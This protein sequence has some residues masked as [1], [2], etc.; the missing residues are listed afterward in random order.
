MT[1]I[2]EHCYVDVHCDQCGEFAVRA[3]VIAESQRLLERGCPGSTYECPPALLATLLE[4]N[5]LESLERAWTTLQSTAHGPVQ[6]V[7]VDD[8]LRVPRQAAK[9]E[10]APPDEPLRRDMSRWDD[11][12]GF[13][14]GTREL[15]PGLLASTRAE[16]FDGQH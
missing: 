15:R 2:L 11:D 14:P 16:G 10:P 9:D 3:D 12:G 6:Q 1:N 7:L 13:V 5:A 8:A 4:R